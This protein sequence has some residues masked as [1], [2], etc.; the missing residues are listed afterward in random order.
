MSKST[1]VEGIDILYQHI[2]KRLRKL[3]GKDPLYKFIGYEESI[4][5]VISKEY[6]VIKIM[7]LFYRECICNDDIKIKNE[8]DYIITSIIEFVVS[9]IKY[10]ENTLTK[11]TIKNFNEYM[12]DMGVCNGCND[13][14]MKSSQ[15]IDEIYCYECRYLKMTKKPNFNGTMPIKIISK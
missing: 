11:H 4:Y 15:I 1:Y 5:K 14:C 12:Y 7:D 6:V 10:L 13:F 3:N 8:F 9:Y 2:D